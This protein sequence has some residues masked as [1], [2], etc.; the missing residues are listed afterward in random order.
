MSEAAR[1]K[2]GRQIV[3]CLLPERRR[4]AFA[5]GKSAWIPRLGCSLFL[6]AATVLTVSPTLVAQTSEAPGANNSGA[7]TDAP[8]QDDWLQRWMQTVD[9]ARAD[10]PHYVAPIITTHVVLV[11]QY[12]YDFSRQQDPTGTATANFGASRGFEFIPTTR[13]E[14]GVS[15]PPYFTHQSAVADGFGDLSFQVKYRVSSAPEGKGDYFVGVFLGGSFPTGA[16]PNGAGHTIWTPTLA[17]AKGMGPVDIQTTLAAGLPAT[18]TDLLGRTVVSNTAV[19]Y[20]I[21]GKI[22]PMLELNSTSW[23][24]GSLDGRHEV[25]LTPGV[26]V[27]SFPLV[28][29]LHLGLGVGM[30]IA[31]SEFRRYNHRWVGS[32]RLPF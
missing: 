5:M 15:P 27:G 22:W 7:A 14:I 20:R 11:E 21:K 24:G 29:R 30:Q 18:G 19:D 10:Q 4:G 9:E 17:A 8:K 32:V 28:E 16:A 26:V 6:T 31:V 1:S 12:R 13:L 23:S 25:F 2:L 3:A